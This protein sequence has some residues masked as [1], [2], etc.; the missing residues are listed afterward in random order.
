LAHELPVALGVDPR[1]G[2]RSCIR[3]LRM[4]ARA[5]IAERLGKKRPTVLDVVQ[6][7]ASTDSRVAKRLS[8]IPECRFAAKISS[9]VCYGTLA[10][11]ALEFILCV[12]LTIY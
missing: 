11:Y 10:R 1:N 5:L 6:A 12:F 2:I 4:P 9:I 7:K 8:S 3:V